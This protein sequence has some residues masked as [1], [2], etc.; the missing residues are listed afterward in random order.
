MTVEKQVCSLVAAANH[1]AT[2]NGK[3]AQRQKL[4]LGG[5]QNREN[6][7]KTEPGP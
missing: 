5:G 7:R 1:F 3:P 4:T 2:I 6:H